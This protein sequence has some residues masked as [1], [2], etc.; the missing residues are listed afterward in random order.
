[1]RKLLVVHRLLEAEER[2]PKRGAASRFDVMAAGASAVLLAAGSLVR[3]IC[4][5]PRREPPA[6]TC[7]RAALDLARQPGSRATA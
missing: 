6:L 5:A 7:R 4:L 3:G 2:L 1:M